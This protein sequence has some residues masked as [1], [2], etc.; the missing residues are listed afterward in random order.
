MLD[1]IEKIAKDLNFKEV[2][3]GSNVSILEPYDDGVFYNLQII[4]GIKVVSNIQLYLD[5]INYKE[6]GEEAAN[7]LYEQRINKNW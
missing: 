7:F 3:S 2:S 5:L 1:N 6:R 4:N